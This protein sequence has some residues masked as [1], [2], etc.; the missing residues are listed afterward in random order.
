MKSLS[1]NPLEY[2]QKIEIHRIE[3]AINSD[4]QT[5]VQLR[6]EIGQKEMI[7]TI[8]ILL[9]E[10]CAFF[11][12][13]K[14]ATKEG[15]KEAARLIIQEFYFL[16]L[17]DLK[18]FFDKFKSGYYG[19][20][21]DRIDGN[22]IMVALRQYSNERIRIAEE[23]NYTKHL[24]LSKPDGVKYIVQIGSNFIRECDDNFE[25][26]KE[27]E[28]AT[29]YSFGVAV[30]VKNQL[31]K[32]CNEGLKVVNSVTLFDFF[33]KNKPELL[34]QGERFKR[35]TAEYYEKKAFIEEDEG[36]SKFEKNNRLRDLAGLKRF[37][38]D[39][40][41]QWEKQYYK[42]IKNLTYDNLP[43]KNSY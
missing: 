4:S 27:K 2:Y 19:Q 5:L 43:S 24:E 11:S 42:S 20:T 37:T 21:F 32:D 39:Q 9:A 14:Q 23:I 22:V 41:K 30:S 16:K 7:A 1:E 18:Y 31:Q 33:E 6:F 25:E 8:S 12:V 36:L 17:E 28:L 10:L 15:L 13:G 35:A 29:A 34:P 40:F 3:D 26:V 38:H